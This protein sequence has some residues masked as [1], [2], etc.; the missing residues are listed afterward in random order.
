MSTVVTCMLHASEQGWGLGGGLT[1]VSAA[2]L[3]DVP[4]IRAER[5]RSTD[6]MAFCH[7]DTFVKRIC[8]HA[9]R[10]D[11]KCSRVSTRA[12]LHTGLTP[13]HGTSGGARGCELLHSLEVHRVRSFLSC[14]TGISEALPAK[15]RV[16]ATLS[17]SWFLVSAHGQRRLRGVA[18]VLQQPL[19]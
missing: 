10:W 3:I 2:K 5:T 19:E 18:E 13:L 11:Q 12:V 17:N 8:A 7:A 4:W 14:T 1:G 9:R 16:E 6:A 15:P